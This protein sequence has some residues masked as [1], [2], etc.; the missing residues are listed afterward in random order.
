MKLIDFIVPYNED[1]RMM[2]TE[3]CKQLFVNRILKKK[4]T[5][6][7]CTGESGEG[8]SY[9]GLK[10]LEI[11]NNYFGVDT[12]THLEDCIIYTPLEYSKK[13]NAMLHEPRL[14]DCRCMI[15]DEARELVSSHLWYS[16]V[17]QAIADVNALH[18]T[19]K[20]LVFVVIVQFI[21]DIDPATRRTIQYYLSCLRPLNQPHVNVFISRLWKDE[22][23][24]ENPKIRRRNVRGYFYTGS[25]NDATTGQFTPGKKMTKF[26][27]TMITV[28]LPPKEVYKEYERINL[29]RKSEILKRKLENL[30]FQIEKEMGYK[31]SKVDS[32]VNYFMEHPELLD[33][34]ETRRRG[35][36]G[37]IVMKQDFKKMFDLSPVEIRDFQRALHLKLEQSDLVRKDAEIEQKKEE[38]I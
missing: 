35:T 11:V 34:I 22:R 37:N 26:T 20:P 4:P 21:K 6:I 2:G 1:Q 24:I 10:I 38:L 32:V 14:K 7:L 16:F 23:D 18:R 25:V 9:T 3:I 29:E 30:L 28:T 12:L 17:N 27:P 33:L 31:S 36:K 5:V 8:K 13:M 19:V 15:L